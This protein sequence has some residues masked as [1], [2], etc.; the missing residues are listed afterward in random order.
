MLKVKI[1]SV[2]SSRSAEEMINKFIANNP[3]NEIV[4]IKIGGDGGSNV[5]TYLIMYNEK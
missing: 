5:M 4:D 1:I 2:Y 3:N